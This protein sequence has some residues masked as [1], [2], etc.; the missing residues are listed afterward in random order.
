MTYDSEY[1][2]FKFNSVDIETLLNCLGYVLW[3]DKCLNGLDKSRIERMYKIFDDASCEN[4]TY[5]NVTATPV[6]NV[7]RV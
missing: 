5:S 4:S 3:N 7:L 2:S 6:G 1:N